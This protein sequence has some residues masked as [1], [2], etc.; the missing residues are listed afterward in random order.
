MDVAKN[1]DWIPRWLT[2]LALLGLTA[3]G[4]FLR[5]YDINVSLYDN[6]ILAHD[7]AMQRATHL[8]GSETA[9]LYYLL[10][11]GSLALGDT[12][13]ALRLPS[14]I[15]GLLSILALFGLVR[16]L[17]SRTAGLLAAAL[18]AFNPYHIVESQFAQPGALLMLFTLLAAW[19]LCV[20]LERRRWYAWLGFTASAL[21]AFAA[22]TRFTP[23]FLALVGGG[24]LYLLFER[25]GNSLKRRIGLAV[26]LALCATSAG[27]RLIETGTNPLGGYRLDLPTASITAA[28]PEANAATDAGDYETRPLGG[29]RPVPDAAGGATRYRLTIYDCLEYLKRYFWN[30]TAW[31]WP[32]LIVLGVWGMVDLWFRV[33]AAAA[34]LTAGFIAAPL[35]LFL[36]TASHPYHPRDFSPCFMLALVFVATGACVMPRF[37]S[38]VLG[39]PRSLRLWR[40]APDARPVRL[41]SAANVLYVLIVAGAAVPLAPVLNRAYQSFPVHGYLPPF[42]GPVNRTPVR[43]WQ[44]L[45]RSISEFAADGDQFVFMTP[46]HL[47]GQ[48][49]AQYYLEHF[50]AWN[51]EE[52]RIRSQSAA[53]TPKLIGNLAKEY[54]MANLWFVGYHSFNAED[55]QPLFKG[56][57]A[58]EMGFYQRNLVEG[59][60]LYYLGAPATNLVQNGGFE[61]ALPAELPEGVAIDADMSWAGQSAARIS[62]T[63]LGGVD[64]Y[65]RLPVAPMGYRLR[66]N[67]F[68]AW[69]DGHP[70]GWELN[71]GAMAAVQHTSGGFQGTAGL[72]LAPSDSVSI[73]RQTIPVG[74][75]PGRSLEIQAW[76]HSETP[77]NLYLVVRYAGPGFQ[78]ERRFAHPGNGQW[79][80]LNLE[81][82]IPDTT[83]PDSITFEIWRT[84]GGTGDAIVDNVEFRVKGAEGRLDPGKPYVLSMA[85]R[86]ENLFGAAGSNTDP[87]GRVRLA[88]EDAAGKIGHAGLIGIQD[89]EDWRQLS[90]VFRPGTEIPADLKNLFVE[91]GIENGTGT[92]WVDNVQLEEGAQ[93]TPFTATFRYPHDETLGAVDLTPLAVPVAW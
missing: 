49:Y 45:F 79:S 80:I 93:P 37:I 13:A 68:E 26:L 51:P 88:W 17:H 18:L 52:N 30:T 16:Y 61:G 69:R 25:G 60:T 19:S 84:P 92:I 58:E 67:H 15:A 44:N 73:V 66:N 2:V 91:V 46:P 81:F 53:P 42:A 55:F 56:A 35:A 59:L 38:R 40:R 83:D 34:P 76:G 86:T 63:E 31:L 85:V 20:L 50:R 82:A 24:V 11:K 36:A 70:V 72:N 22:D 7:L 3:Y 41:V 62:R 8:L 28:V 1:L 48:R 57:G 78:E 74:V 23:V 27:G 39:A 65:L 10:A 6:E 21:L 87:A 9:P 14:L 12:E 77:N 33:P 89:G 64:P 71:E 32:V 47:H 5:G 75:A 90:A 43:D 54:P 29:G 4:A